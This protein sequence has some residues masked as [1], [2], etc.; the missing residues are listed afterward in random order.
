MPQR[1]RFGPP[2]SY[3][4]RRVKR[5]VT[6]ALGSSFCARTV[7]VTEIVFAFAVNPFS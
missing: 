4:L 6:F 5:H 3:R 7:I 2:C 1:K